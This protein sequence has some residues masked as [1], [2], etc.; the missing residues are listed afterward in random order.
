MLMRG[1]TGNAQLWTLD[2]AATG[3]GRQP[4][5]Y[6]EEKNGLSQAQFSPE[7]TGPPRWV[8]YTSGESG[9]RREIYVQSF[10]SGGGKFQISN[11]GGSQPRWRSDGRELFY[12]SGDGRLMAVDVKLAPQFSPGIPHA[13]FE[14]P[15]RPEFSSVAFQ[16]DVAPDGQR[17]L[18][19]APRFESG[20]QETITVELNWLAGVK[21]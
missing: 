15:T 6:L 14:S 8:A 19:N 7:T 12:I 2:L 21:K 5:A 16:Y 18:V 20:G 11:G 10:P 1:A 4:V 13:L 9:Q 17:F 3:G